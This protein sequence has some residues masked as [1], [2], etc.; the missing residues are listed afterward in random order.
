MGFHKLKQTWIANEIQENKQRQN[1]SQKE[2]QSEI[3]KIKWYPKSE[4]IDI[5]FLGCV[6]CSTNGDLLGKI[7]IL[8][9]SSGLTDAKYGEEL[10]WFLSVPLLPLHLK[11]PSWCIQDCLWGF[12]PSFPVTLTHTPFE[13][14]LVKHSLALGLL[15][16]LIHF[17]RCFSTVR[18][19]P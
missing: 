19:H 1:I 12:Q 17:L 11:F 7:K 5:G 6:E 13:K 15:V 9:P 10:N 16:T 8:V 18:E 3:V 2:A 4:K 14:S